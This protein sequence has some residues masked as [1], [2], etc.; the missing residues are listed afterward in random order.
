M[1][2]TTINKYVEKLLVMIVELMFNVNQIPK[3][4]FQNYF[5]E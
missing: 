4:S 5:E 3:C 2:L 1:L